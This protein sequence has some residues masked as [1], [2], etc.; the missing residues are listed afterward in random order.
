MSEITYDPRER[1]HNELET[2][3][4]AMDGV[5]SRIWTML[6]GIIQA[7]T[8]NNGAPYAKVK[9]AVMGR[10]IDSGQKI[11]FCNLPELPECPLWFPRGGGYSLT[12]PVSKGDECMVIFSARSIDEWFTQGKAAPAYDLRMTDLS[13][14]IAVV[15]LMSQKR[16]LKNISTNS[17]QL[18]SDDGKNFVNLSDG[19]ITIQAQ[20]G[21]TLQVGQA[22]LQI[23]SKGI[24][25]NKQT[26]IQ[27]NLNV[28][29]GIV[30]TDDVQ[31]SGISL[32]SHVHGGVKSGGDST[33]APE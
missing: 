32:N 5:H 14:G 2:H 27:A 20:N 11:T 24:N 15:G 19:N 17:C 22:E 16:P 18:R 30:A 25:I 21:I 26:T 10:T 13:D 1:F 23:T 3:Y 9:L 12:F 7:V 29:G 31:G 6:P 33:G 4:M 28:S 8:W